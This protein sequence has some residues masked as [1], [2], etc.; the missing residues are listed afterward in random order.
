MRSAREENVQEESAIKRGAQ[1]AAKKQVKKLG[2][3]ALKKYGKVAA[4]A[5]AKA[6]IA[7]IKA[8][9]VFLSGLGAPFILTVI[10]IILLVVI[11]FVATS[12]L[13]SWGDKSVLNPD[14]YE[15][16]NYIQEAA[17]NS[18]DN[19]KIEQR[20]YKVPPELIISAMQIYEGNSKSDASTE[21][22]VDLFVEAL[23]PTFNY[24]VKEGLIES[25]QTTCK[26]G[27]CTSVEKSSTFELNMFTSVQAWDQTLVID[28]TP[29]FNEW[30]ETVLH[31]VEKRKMPT[32]D[33]EGELI[34]GE[35]WYK[36]IPYTI[37]TKTRSETFVSIPVTNVDYS[38]FDA[39]LR[40]APFNYGQADINM[41][42][43]LYMA[44]GGDIRYSEWANGNSFVGFN[45]TIVAGGNIPTEFMEVYL[46]AEKKYKVEW[47]YLASFHYVE[48]GFS[49][50]PTM[51]SSVGAQGHMQ[52]MPCTWVGWNY[53]GCGGNGSLAI[54]EKDMHNPLIIQKYGGYGIDGDG[55]GKASPWEI[56]DA[57]FASAR[58]MNDVGWQKSKDSAIFNYN[59]SQA[60]VDKIHKYA[61]QFKSNAIY[62]PGDGAI[63]ALAPGSFMRPTVGNNTSGFGGRVIGGSKKYHY[64]IDVA[65]TSAPPVVAVAEGVV[66]RA[67]SFCSPKGYYGSTCGGGWGNHLWVKHTVGGRTY[68][69]VY[70]HLSK[71]AV[72][73]G[74]KV[75]QG[76]LLGNM[77]NSGS[78]TGMHLHFELHSP[79]RVSNSNVL[80]PA[81]YIP[82]N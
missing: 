29:H 60:Y 66:T 22:A 11:I 70:A 28:N 43:A 65:S 32:Y 45:G 56:K 50:H 76:Q 9:I 38:Y 53:P 75:I 2:K 26:E 7:G 61:N 24:E 55:N 18:I 23:T 78:S 37:T 74:Q 79:A 46:A 47:Y 41:V 80:N 20:Q 59:K 21:D 71:V 54:P 3:K 57:I 48:T 49:T 16:Q 8:L 35:Y 51:V 44:T 63:P 82:M 14:A 12:L 36:E 58:Y 39:V 5:A 15:L 64:G 34:P 30:Q 73:V 25:V 67:Q 81:L 31:R 4:K 77:G 13:F 40:A 6:S 27:K 69:A 33:D 19:S 1:N 72:S 52:F 17:N 10:G 62:K 68:E 42:E